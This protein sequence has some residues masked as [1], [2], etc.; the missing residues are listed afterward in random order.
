VFDACVAAALVVVLSPLLAALAVLVKLEGRGPVLFRQ[1]RVGRGGVEFE[2]VKF[3][4]MCVD[5]EAKLAALKAGN[6][7]TGPLFKMDGADPR[8]TRI[9][10][11]LRASSLDE[12]PQ[13]FNVL[14]GD[15]SLV[16]PRPALAAE[17]AE[18][19]AE[20]NARHDV[21]P[22]ITG[23]WQ[24]EA[25]D[26]PSFE[27]YRRLDLFYVENWSLAL[28]LMILLGTVEQILVRPFLNRRRPTPAPLATAAA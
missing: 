4:S 11:F 1:R 28:D 9:G 6:E 16:G 23:L 12:L 22:G 24:I 26:N 19:P 15:M 17:V 5:A 27:A 10:R 7:R 25:R 20:L 14:R 3:R 8:V 13:L 18:F 2:M 21:R